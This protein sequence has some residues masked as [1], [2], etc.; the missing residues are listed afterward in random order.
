MPSP[1]S[2]ILFICLIHFLPSCFSESKPGVAGKAVPTA[3][4]SISS[5]NSGSDSSSISSGGSSGSGAESAVMVWMTELRYS[6]EMECMT[7]L[8]SKSIRR[9]CDAASFTA[10][11]R[12]IKSNFASLTLWV[13]LFLSLSLSLSLCVSERAIFFHIV[14]FLFFILLCYLDFLVVI[15]TIF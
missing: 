11:G 12:A 7:V 8:Q 1:L 5:P 13:F 2:K 4:C 3:M 15:L 14:F 6:T 10:A 9:G